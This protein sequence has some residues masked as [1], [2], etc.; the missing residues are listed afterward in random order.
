MPS[1]PQ[2]WSLLL[3]GSALNEHMEPLYLENLR[4]Y[5]Q[6]LAEE[7]QEQLRQLPISGGDVSEAAAIQASA[8]SEHT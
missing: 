4:G 1:A 3:D 6:T 2:A 8:D 7:G 5:L